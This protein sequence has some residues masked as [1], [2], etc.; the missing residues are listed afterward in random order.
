MKIMVNTIRFDFKPD[1]SKMFNGEN[2]EIPD[3][4][5]NIGTLLNNQTKVNGWIEVNDLY[6]LA[7]R[8]SEGQTITAV[9]L[10]KAREI[11]S[12]NAFIIDL[13][14]TGFGWETLEEKLENLNFMPNIVYPTFS[15]Y[16]DLDIRCRL[17]YIL[18]KEWKFTPKK[19]EKQKKMFEAIMVAIQ[20]HLLGQNIQIDAQ[21]K[22]ANRLFYGTNKDATVTN[23]TLYTMD[24]FKALVGQYRAFCEP[25]LN[26]DDIAKLN[27][28]KLKWPTTP[29]RY[30]D[31][32]LFR[33]L[34]IAA[35]YG[36][37]F[38]PEKYQRLLDYKKGVI[39][40]KLYDSVCSS[41]RAFLA[42]ILYQYLS[43]NDYID[44]DYRSDFYRIICEKY[45]EIDSVS[46]REGK[47]PLVN[48]FKAGVKAIPRFVPNKF[49]INGV[50]YDSPEAALI[51]LKENY[52]KHMKRMEELLNYKGKTIIMEANNYDQRPQDY[53]FETGKLKK[54][55]FPD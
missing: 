19:R 10:D 37:L 13:D 26:R 50:V 42:G 46:S 41:S 45:K 5:G 28:E 8:V 9:T 31:T 15:H 34:Y 54:K 27:K 6:D 24:D 55:I 1:L 33:D 21:C 2:C 32:N 3:V 29:G 22:N 17:V 53:D 48:R 43:N 18:D 16:D 51:Q 11:E 4:T 40:N 52:D 47:E 14:E 38:I 49:T 35:G 36:G 20:Q 12:A 25:V 7:S 30:S 44:H 23:D 39:D